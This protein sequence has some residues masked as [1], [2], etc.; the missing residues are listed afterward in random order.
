MWA[1]SMGPPT[2]QQAVLQGKGKGGSLNGTGINCEIP[3]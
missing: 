2:F 3:V 1:D